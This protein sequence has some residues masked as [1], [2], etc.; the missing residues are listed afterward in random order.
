MNIQTIFFRNMDLILEKANF[1][2]ENSIFQPTSPRNQKLK[3]AIAVSGGADSTSLLILADQYA[4]QYEIPIVAYTVNHNLRHNSLQEAIQVHN[5]AK[6]LGIE[7]RILNWEHDTIKF[8]HIEKEA[9]NARYD[10]L[11]RSMLADNANF[12]L[13]AHTENDLVETFILRKLWH[14]KERGLAG[15]SA[16]SDFKCGMFLG[17]PFLN[18]KKQQLMEFLRTINVDWVHD[19][20]NDDPNYQRVKIRQRLLKNQKLHNITLKKVHTFAQKRYQKEEDILNWLYYHAYFNQTLFSLELPKRD[21]LQYENTQE[22]LQI[23]ISIVGGAETPIVVNDNILAKVFTEKK[24]TLGR[25]V[26]ET[27]QYSIKIYRENKNQTTISRQDGNIFD[28]RIQVDF[29]HPQA[30]TVSFLNKDGL[31]S[32]LNEKIIENMKEKEISISTPAIFDENGD[33]LAA[34]FCGYKKD[35]L[36]WGE[37]KFANT[38]I[39]FLHLNHTPVNNISTDIL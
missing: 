16:L 28:N 1:Y 32:L 23:V 2:R 19:P 22:L 39:P 37:I 12:L 11:R 15:I 24:F 6:M 7:H 20:S 18:L 21:L 5:F 34:H 26:I 25:C 35:S 10:L 36:E 17:R 13:T 14:S 3:L 27:S 9:R 4:K 31:F 29:I 38:F 30:K 8:G 33:I